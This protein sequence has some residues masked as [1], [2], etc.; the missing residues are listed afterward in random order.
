M[1]LASL[2]GSN[3]TFRFTFWKLVFFFLMAAGLYATFVRFTQGLGASTHLTDQFPWGIWISFDV[4]CG[5]ML[6]AGGFTLTAAVHIFN[7]KRMH[8][9]IRPTILTAFLGYVLVCMA[10]MYDLGKPY[11]I[12]HPLI[13]RNPHSVMFEVAYCVMLYTTVLALEFSPI[14]LERFGLQRPLK[15]VRTIL[16]PLVITG[17]I[18]STLHQ[19]SLG[20]LYLIVP[21]KLHPFWY[22]PLLPVFFFLS[23]IAVGLAMTIFESSMS[24]RHLGLQLELPVL[25][26]LGRVL[27]VV[28]GLYAIL[29][30]E[31]LARRGVLPLT[32][33]PGYEMYLFWLEITLAILLPLALLVQSRVRSSPTGLYWSAVLVVLG[34]ITNRMNVSITGFEGSTGVRYFPKWS[35]VAVTGMVIG[36]GFALFGLAVKYLPIFPREHLA[37]QEQSAEP[38]EA[39]AVAP[40]LEHAGD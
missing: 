25:Q 19:S 16:I 13:M 17:V 8:S 9:I 22:S 12:W 1:N 3:K 2:T 32:V 23:A 4:L 36:A 30:F 10:L 5:V 35:E 11:N 6:A 31:D 20:T 14:V 7:I 40:V 28:L 21:E 38:M 26:E 15:V 33:R 18:L 37:L 27:V 39:V 29:R 24:A 34:F